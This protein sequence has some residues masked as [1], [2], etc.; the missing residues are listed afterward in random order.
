[1]GLELESE[2]T[3]PTTEPSA[4]IF[5]SAADLSL[6]KDSKLRAAILLKDAQMAELQKQNLL[7]KIYLKYSLLNTAEINEETGEVFYPAK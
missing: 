7:L 2:S 4:S 5:I 1:M 6:L 3:P